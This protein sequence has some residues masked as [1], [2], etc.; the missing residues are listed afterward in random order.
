[1]QAGRSA[2]LVRHDGEGGWYNACELGASL[3]RYSDGEGWCSVYEGSDGY[4]L[5]GARCLDRTHCSPPDLL[6]VPTLRTMWG[7]ACIVDTRSI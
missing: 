2:T 5:F 7:G 3:P 1:M 6:D 4:M